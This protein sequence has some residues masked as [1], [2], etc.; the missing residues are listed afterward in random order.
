MKILQSP[1]DRLKF[2]ALY[3][4]SLITIILFV[5]IC[6]NVR[7]TIIESEEKVD[8]IDYLVYCKHAAVFWIYI[9]SNIGVR[10][11]YL[12]DSPSIQLAQCRL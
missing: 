2:F 7:G 1:Q 4:L 5:L 8:D 3:K 12:S 6:R 9:L 11:L 10:T